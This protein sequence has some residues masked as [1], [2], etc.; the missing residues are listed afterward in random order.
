MA[1]DS[2]ALHIYD[3]RALQSSASSSTKPQATHHPHSDYI[4]SLT[5]LPPSNT[6]TSGLPKQWITTG[7]TTLA[8]TDIRK[9]VVKQ[10]EDQE[11][12]LVSTAYVT[13][14]SSKRTSVGAKAVVGG[15]DG[16]ITLWESG[17]WDDQ[18]ER[19]IVDRGDGVGGGDSLDAMVQVPDE[20]GLGKM[21]AVGMGG[22]KIRFVKLGQNK[23]V[24][25]CVH[26]DVEG[27]AGL[28]FDVAGRM[29]SGG[30]QVVKV[31][32]EKVGEEDEDK[33][34]EQI[35]GVTKRARAGS[36]D[37]SDDDDD[38]SSE[39]SSSEGE[40]PQRK[41]KRKK[42][43]RGKAPNGKANGLSFKGLD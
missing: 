28:G 39:E 40:K 25:E 43:S 1:N 9:G 31:W 27:V 13:G 6:S 33:E 34:M 19:I 11:E 41:R 2:S 23:V 14:L 16:V 4:S 17:V 3:L 32:G 22:G 10:S 20:M 37:S 35:D 30:G 21:V 38:E 7:G 12:E 8:L 26:D 15:A 18:D 36:D 5:P 42:R 24:G 29:I